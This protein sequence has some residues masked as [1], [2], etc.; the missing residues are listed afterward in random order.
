MRAARRVNAPRSP[1]LD[2][3][4]Y[5]SRSFRRL[6]VW[7]SRICCAI[8]LAG[9]TLRRRA[10]GLSAASG[11]ATHGMR[12][13][14]LPDRTPAKRCNASRASAFYRPTRPRCLWT[15][16][17][18]TTACAVTD[19]FPIGAARSRAVM[20]TSSICTVPGTAS[21]VASRAAAARPIDSQTVKRAVPRDE[22]LHPL[23]DRGRGLVMHRSDE[24][25]DVGERFGHIAR[26]HRQQ[27]FL[28]GPPEILLE[29]RHVA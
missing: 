15:A 13:P 9:A 21:S 22:S 1:P 16:A 23:L 3:I 4:L 10:R 8:G 12:F 14:S 25:F 17:R 20:P 18:R 24:L 29:Q 6:G 11:S 5:A 28:G 7:R 27:A 19:T 26:L 2:R